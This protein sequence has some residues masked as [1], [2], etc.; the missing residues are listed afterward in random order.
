VDDTEVERWRRKHDPAELRGDGERDLEAV[1]LR[2]GDL[3]EDEQEQT[4][5]SSKR[6]GSSLRYVNATRKP[7]LLP[8]MVLPSEFEKVTKL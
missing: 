8:G 6:N 4:D 3:V 2:T 1:H 5:A 7:A